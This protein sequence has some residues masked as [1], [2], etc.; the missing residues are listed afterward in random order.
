MTFEN[1]LECSSGASSIIT[2][3]SF[4][5][6]TRRRCHQPRVAYLQLSPGP[7]LRWANRGANTSVPQCQ[8]T[9]PANYEVHGATT[10][11]DD[12]PSVPTAEYAGHNPCALFYGRASF[13]TTPVRPSNTGPSAHQSPRH[14]YRNQADARGNVPASN[15]QQASTSTGYPFVPPGLVPFARAAC[16]SSA[17]RARTADLR[18]Y[19]VTQGFGVGVIQGW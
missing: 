6:K 11:N 17:A 10:A 2:S 14:A 18:W 5:A 12:A 3:R 9:A 7:K 8:S 13:P 4:C 15:T 19:V 16:T 1:H